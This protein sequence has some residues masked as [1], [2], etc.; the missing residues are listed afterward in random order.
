[1]SHMM[2]VDASVSKMYTFSTECKK[3]QPSSTM[4]LHS[5]PQLLDKH[6]TM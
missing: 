4:T 1:M 5:E 2:L 6:V 3:K